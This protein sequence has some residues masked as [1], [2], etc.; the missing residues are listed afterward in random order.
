MDKKDNFK[1]Q[2][3]G[4]IRLKSL[5]EFNQVCEE[6][7]GKVISPGGA[8]DMLHVS[9]AYIHQL[10]KEKRIR[11]YRFSYNDLDN[12]NLSL[13]LR[14]LLNRKRGVYIYIP[15]VDLEVIQK[16]MKKRKEDRYRDD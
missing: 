5:D 13:A 8:A 1:S 2:K 11:A 16:E 10:E 7:E 14:I 3:K 4:T 15:V 9:R 6:F 12:S